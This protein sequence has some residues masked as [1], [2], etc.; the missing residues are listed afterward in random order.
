MVHALW[1]LEGF[2]QTKNKPSPFTRKTCLVL[3]EAPSIKNPLESLHRAQGLPTFSGATWWRTINNKQD[4]GNWVVKF[5]VEEGSIMLWWADTL[6]VQDT[7]RIIG[8]LV[9]LMAHE[10]GAEESRMLKII[11]VKLLAFR[12]NCIKSHLPH[13]ATKL[14]NLRFKKFNPYSYLLQ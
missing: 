3:E 9:R 6:G 11:C 2:K 10:K 14:R 1:F 7:L 5:G 8:C 12:P 13:A 4:I